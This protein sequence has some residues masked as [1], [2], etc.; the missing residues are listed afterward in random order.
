[1]MHKWLKLYNQEWNDHIRP[2]DIKEWEVDKFIKKEAIE[3]FFL[4]LREDGFFYN[5]VEPQKHSRKAIDFLLTQKHEVYIVTAYVPEGCLDK[6]NWIKKYFPEV[7]DNN[8]I[9]CNNKS[10]LKLDVLIDD[11]EHNFVNF[12]GK[13]IIYTQPWNVEYNK[14]NFRLNSWKDIF[15]IDFL[16]YK[17]EK[18]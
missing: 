1:M 2:I 14:A 12:K 17:L 4:Y 16:K 5:G 10:L 6:V 13:K 15:E 18:I 7:K 11:G 9:F 3:K 8:I